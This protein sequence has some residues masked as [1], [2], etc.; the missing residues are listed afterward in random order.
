MLQVSKSDGFGA[1][2]SHRDQG[3]INRLHAAAVLSLRYAPSPMPILNDLL[4]EAPGFIMARL[5]RAGLMLVGSDKRRQADLQKDFAVL[6]RYRP[7]ANAREAAHIRAIRLWLSGDFYAASQAYADILADYPRD[8]IALQIGHQTDFLL[9][10]VQ[11]TRDRPARAL[12]H[13]SRADAEYSYLLGM[14]AFG[15]E[16]AG[17]YAQAEAMALESVSLNP[18]DAWGVHALAHCY[19]MQGKTEAGLAYMTSHEGDWAHDSFLAIH[20]RWHLCLYLLEVCRFEDAL[21]AWDSYIGPRGDAEMM[22]LHDAS[23]L[24]WRLQLDGVETGTRWDGVADGYEA[25]AEQAWM[26]FNDMHAMFAFVA[27]GRRSSQARLIAALERAATGSGTSAAVIRAAGLPIVRAIAAYGRGDWS[28]AAEGLS[29]V[30][31]LSHLIGGS[32]AQRDV[33]NLTLI[34][35]AS[36]AGETRRVAGLVAERRLMKPESPLTGFLL[37][38]APKSA[39][40]M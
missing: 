24:L 18:A 7:Q 38:R 19:E 16:E 32:L 28:G 3:Q 20:N 1:P 11:S 37:N 21:A 39:L 2:V 13:W 14:Q 33:L 40:T 15:L 36:R 29:A 25:F 31:H 4:T 26:P 22:D 10:Q 8:L 9:G 34:D 6:E 35:A 17:H 30:R 27:T 23:A 12:P 5:L